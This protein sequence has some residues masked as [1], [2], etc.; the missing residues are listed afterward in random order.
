[1]KKLVL[2]VAA[3]TAC[4]FIR[5]GNA[6][7]KPTPEPVPVPVYNW[8][9]W[10]A[11]GNVGYGW[12]R[13]SN[14]SMSFIDTSGAGLTGYVASGGIAPIAV[15]PKGMVG[16][17]QFGYNWQTRTNFVLGVVNDFQ[18]SA[19]KGTGTY[20]SAPGTVGPPGISTL[21]HRLEWFDTVRGR[22]GWTQQNWLWYATGGLAYGQFKDS[23]TFSSTGV[24]Q[25]AGSQ[26]QIKAGWTLGAGLEYGWSQW[27]A[28]VE[29]LYVDLGR[30]G[31]TETFSGYGG[32]G[33]DSVTMSNRDAFQ[34]VRAVINYRF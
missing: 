1:V 31:V 3:I 2:L 12:G 5:A 4:G 14:T 7:G 8:T 17:L 21:Q 26:S 24:E 9:G 20:L 19:L 23:L 6:A 29:Y 27:S 13:S 34:I 18:G 22:L 33:G 10:Y 32:A 16:G 25:A 30:S 15:D 28:G 11:G